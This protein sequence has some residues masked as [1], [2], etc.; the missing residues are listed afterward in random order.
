MGFFGY[1]SAPSPDGAELY[2]FRY[3]YNNNYVTDGPY[4]AHMAGN[5]ITFNLTNFKAN[6]S[7][8]NTVIPTMDKPS[9]LPNVI[10]E[11]NFYPDSP[12]TITY[13][14]ETL[15]NYIRNDELTLIYI[16][17]DTAECH[18]KVLNEEDINIKFKPPSIFN[19]F[20][21]EIGGTRYTKSKK[22][23]T[24]R[25]KTKKNYKRR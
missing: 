22:K 3:L 14:K 20:K 25:R 10:C 8:T 21:R 18:E 4:N 11:P 13:T 17:S 5:V 12:Q 15:L 16:Y 1:N 23:P 19:R 9:I 2:L 7:F 24:K 6:R